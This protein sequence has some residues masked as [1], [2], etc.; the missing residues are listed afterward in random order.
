MAGKTFVVTIE[1]TEYDDFSKFQRPIICVFGGFLSAFKEILRFFYKLSIEY[2]RS[3]LGHDNL[4]DILVGTGILSKYFFQKHRDQ[5]EKTE[6]EPDDYVDM[7]CSF[8]DDR[9]MKILEKRMLGKKIMFL[10]SLWVRCVV[11]SPNPNMYKTFA[12]CTSLYSNFDWH[13]DNSD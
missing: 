3:V 8:L 7:I 9:M 4:E 2:G 1:T 6:E 10:D 5:F 11:L 13:E 12:T